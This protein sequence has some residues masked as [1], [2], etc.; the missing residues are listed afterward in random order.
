MIFRHPLDDILGKKSKV[1]A[2]RF[3]VNFGKE[4]SIRELANEIGLVPANVSEILKE[5]EKA[6]VLSSKQIGR[7]VVFRLNAEQHLV[8]NLIVPLFR[9]ER[10][11]LEEAMMFISKSVDAKEVSLALFGSVARKEE[12]FGSDFDLLV[13]VKNKDDVQALENLLLDISPEFSLHFGNHLSPVV[14]SRSDFASRYK[15]GDKLIRN[16]CRDGHVFHGK[17]FSELL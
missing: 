4:V 3:L 9:D 12:R 17:S 5:L 16:I 13:V 14:I 1:K 15:K 8:K 6:G 2:L 10:K 11:V 7:S